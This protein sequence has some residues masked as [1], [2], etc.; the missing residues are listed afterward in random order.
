MKRSF[1]VLMMIILSS[2]LYGQNSS[3]A[4]PFVV[5]DRNPVSAA[6][7]GAS[8]VRTGDIA[9]ASYSNAAVIPFSS[10][11]SDISVG[12]TSWLPESANTNFINVAGAGKIGDN[13]GLS[14]GFT[15]G[16][17]PAYEITDENG[18]ISGKFAPKDLQLNLGLAW[19]FLPYLGVGANVKYVSS[20]LAKSVN[21]GAVASDIFLMSSFDGLKVALGANNIGTKVKS[22]SGASFS[23]PSSIALGLGYEDVFADK[24]GLSFLLDAD[25]YLYGAYSASVGAEYCYNDMFAFRTGYN[26]AKECP[27]PSYFSFGLGLKFSSFKIDFAY[28]AVSSPIKLGNNLVL[29]LGVAF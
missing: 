8:L 29:S 11:K 21:S 18:D 9:Y 10:R 26:Y 24:H 16:L 23:L 3:I 4:L 17:N 13:F 2:S 15:T 1:L 5:A 12:Y 28:Q 20:S 7:G 19:K 25:Y 27:V 22:A 14:L 6:M